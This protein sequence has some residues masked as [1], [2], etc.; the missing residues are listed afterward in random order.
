MSICYVITLIVTDISNNWVILN[1]ILLKGFTPHALFIIFRIIFTYYAWILLYISNT[2]LTVCISFK[3][4]NIHSISYHLIDVECQEKALLIL[5]IYMLIWGKYY[6]LNFYLAIY[7]LYIFFYPFK[8][9]DHDVFICHFYALHKNQIVF[10]T[11]HQL[12]STLQCN[13]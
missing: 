4:K 12:I 7:R 3:Y 11:C 9:Q 5:Q 8:I 6:L 13:I 10:H 2:T 1:L